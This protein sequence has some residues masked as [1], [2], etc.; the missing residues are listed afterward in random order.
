[1]N[2]KFG[3]SSWP[4]P[5]CGRL[6]HKVGVVIPQDNN[7][8]GYVYLATLLFEKKLRWSLDCP[9]NTHVKFEVRGFNRFD[10]ISI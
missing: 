7:L 6:L 10:A 1:M 8:E 9:E 3:H 5:L 2:Y 4:R